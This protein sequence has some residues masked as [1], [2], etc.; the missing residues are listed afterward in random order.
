MLRR[1]IMVT[2]LAVDCCAPIST[3]Q[4]PVFSI[5]A[6]INSLNSLSGRYERVW[7]F[8]LAIFRV[9]FCGM[10]ATSSTKSK[11]N[12]KATKPSTPTEIV[13]SQ[14]STTFMVVEFE[15]KKDDE[16]IVGIICSTWIV[17][18]VMPNDEHGM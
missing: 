3:N 14:P 11:G 10:M 8:F 9:Y 7:L 12:S 1:A 15:E 16:H 5:G 2:P 18:L 6:Q 13:K 4:K 17:K